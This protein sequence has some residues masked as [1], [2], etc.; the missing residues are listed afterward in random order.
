MSD[1]KLTVA[2]MG[3]NEHGR[4][5]LEAASMNS[6]YEL[7]AVADKDG[8]LAEKYGKEYGCKSYD[9]Y[10]QLIIQNELDCLLVGAGLYSCDEYLHQAIKKRFN[11]LKWPPAGRSFEEAVKFVKLSEDNNVQ[12]CVANINRLS[13]SFLSFSKSISEGSIE[14]VYMLEGVCNTGVEVFPAWHNDREL[15][16]GGVLL[17]SCYQL[18]DQIIMNF[19]LPQETYCVATNTA[20]DRQQ[21][22]YLTEDTSIVTLKFKED[23]VGHI[24]ASKVFGPKESFLRVFGKNRILTL[25]DDYILVCDN[26]GNII[27][28]QQYEFDKKVCTERLLDKYALSIKKADKNKP[29]SPGRENLKNMAVIESAYLSA[30]TGM[31][32]SVMRVLEMGQIESINI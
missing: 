5:L 7:T 28:Q 20:G 4:L 9:D 26:E 24:T 11:I 25:G 1:K 13:D 17:R 27:Y 21:R 10:R 12:F 32:E 16:G 19:S 3:L 31:P 30:R 2:V 18:I 23:L 22:H 15:S 29:F 8:L 6:H 14:H